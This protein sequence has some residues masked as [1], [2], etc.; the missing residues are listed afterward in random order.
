MS[1]PVDRKGIDIGVDPARIRRQKLAIERIDGVGLYPVVGIN[2]IN[3]F[4][5][6]H[7]FENIVD[8]TIAR[9]AGPCILAEDDVN[10]WMSRRIKRQAIKHFAA[11]ITIDGHHDLR[12]ENRF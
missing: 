9:T 10:V 11:R 4:N 3:R 12:A 8:S 1:A 5:I 2:E 7:L 6:R